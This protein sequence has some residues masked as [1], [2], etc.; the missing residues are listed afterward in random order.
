M[1]MVAA[2][3]PTSLKLSWWLALDAEML[4]MVQGKITSFSSTSLQ[5][6]RGFLRWTKKS[7]ALSVDF[8]LSLESNTTIFLLAHSHII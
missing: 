6:F 2:S 4:Y 8:A 1:V 7:V 3:K 5:C